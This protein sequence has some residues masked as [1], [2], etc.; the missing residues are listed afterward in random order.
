MIIVCQR[1]ETTGTELGQLY[2]NTRLSLTSFYLGM[3]ARRTLL[4]W[5]TRHHW[6]TRAPAACCLD[7]DSS[8]DPLSDN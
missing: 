3:A 1:T 8:C 6:N 5:A 2:F 7:Y 4:L